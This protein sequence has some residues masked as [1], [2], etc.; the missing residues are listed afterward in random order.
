MCLCAAVTLSNMQRPARPIT[1]KTLRCN[2][3]AVWYK[4]ADS[5]F[6]WLIYREV[7]SFFN[8]F[9][10]KCVYEAYALYLEIVDYTWITA[11]TQETW[12]LYQISRHLFSPLFSTTCMWTPMWLKEEGDF[13]SFVFFPNDENLKLCLL[14]H[15]SYRFSWNVL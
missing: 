1:I 13:I 3:L 2:F 11:E 15:C 12:C 14:T 9:T 7:C 4:G 8:V 10:L 6:P 5:H